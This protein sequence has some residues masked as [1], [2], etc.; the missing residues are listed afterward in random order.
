MGLVFDCYEILI[1]Y[2]YSSLLVQFSRFSCPYQDFD[3][4]IL[5]LHFYYLF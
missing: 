1:F 5:V 2:D 3:Y 4:Q